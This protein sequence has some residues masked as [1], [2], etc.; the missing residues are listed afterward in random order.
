MPLP[1]TKIW[2]FAAPVALSLTLGTGAMLMAQDNKAKPATDKPAAEKT[3]KP[4]EAGKTTTTASGLKITITEEAKNPGAMPGDI[5]WVH[6]TGKLSTGEEFDSSVGKQPFKFTL[7]SGQVIKGWDEGVVGMKVGEKR[8]LTIPSELGYGAQGAPPKI[9]G[10]ATLVF[11]IEM[12]GL[13]RPG[14]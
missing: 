9:P 13:A 2:K 4:A 7:G 5:V 11:D 8:Q 14:K 3:D 12:I 10:G 1:K 6:Y